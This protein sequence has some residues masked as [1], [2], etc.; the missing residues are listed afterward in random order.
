MA[1]LFPFRP[2]SPELRQEPRLVNLDDGTADEVFAA[3][4]SDTARNILTELYE[5]PTTAS[6]VADAVDTSLQNARYHLDKLTDAGL[7]EDVDTWYSSRGTEMTVYA[8]TNEPLVVAAGREESTGIL[9]EALQ[10]VLGAVGVLGLA[11]LVVDRLARPSLVDNSGSFDREP[12]AAPESETAAFATDTATRGAERTDDGG[13]GALDVTPT[14]AEATTT[15]SPVAT[16]P[17]DTGTSVA[18]ETASFATETPADA[19]AATR[20]VVATREVTGTQA[21]THSTE[22]TD[23]TRAA[24]EEGTRTATPA[25]T[26]LSTSFTSGGDAIG[27][28]TPERTM[29]MAGGSGFGD[30]L[31]TLPPGALFFAGGLLMIAL[32]AAWWYGFGGRTRIA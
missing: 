28:V 6:E 4:S 22:L 3:L 2:E 16:D 23:A 29:E 9:R 19:D 24:T 1:R 18:T 14:E 31:G 27:T 30:L 25:A 7:I 15:P 10:R 13:V 12:A 8:P 17:P 21:E 20:T 32:G 11:S 26:D 5:E